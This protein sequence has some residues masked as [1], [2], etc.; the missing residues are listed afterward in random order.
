MIDGYRALIDPRALGFEVICFAFVHLAA[1]SEAELA[2]FETRVRGW[3]EVR[4]CWTLSGDID[5]IL[6]CV[7][8]DLPAFQAFVS[9]LSATPNVRNIRTSLAL[10]PVKNAAIAPIG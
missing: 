4:E 7:T 2:D 8:R 1:Q 9:R 10:K 3:P 6:K 5:F